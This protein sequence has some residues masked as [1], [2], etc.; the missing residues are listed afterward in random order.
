MSPEPVL[1]MGPHL[2]DY[3]MGHLPHAQVKYVLL[4]VCLY[5]VNHS[6]ASH[7]RNRS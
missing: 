6:L 5:S 1:E 2:K 4:I 7:L 3:G